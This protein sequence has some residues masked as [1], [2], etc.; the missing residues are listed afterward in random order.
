VLLSNSL[1]QNCLFITDSKWN[2]DET[3][4]HFHRISPMYKGTREQK[5]KQISVP[6]AREETV[7]HTLGICKHEVKTHMK[8]HH[9]THD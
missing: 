6:F 9:Q 7:S 4:F 2:K 3:L 1:Q 5:V 8:N